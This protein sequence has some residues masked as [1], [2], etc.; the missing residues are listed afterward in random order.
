MDY[1][2]G[3]LIADHRVQ[4][5]FAAMECEPGCAV[6]LADAERSAEA[7]AA[8]C[9]GLPHTVLH[10]IEK[11]LKSDLNVRWVWPLCELYREFFSRRYA[12]SQTYK[13]GVRVFQFKF[14]ANSIAEA[15]RRLLEEYSRMGRTLTLREK[16]RIE[17]QVEWYY[18]HAISDEH[19][20]IRS[21]LK[22]NRNRVRKGV[23]EAQ[24][25]LD[26]CDA[27]YDLW[28]CPGCAA[29]GRKKRRVRPMGPN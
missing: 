16:K 20:A 2:V 12:A 22:D 25:L 5:F 23:R 26:R 1:L 24:A 14:E 11:F 21:I 15:R 29:V 13:A 19:D 9:T 10:R 7:L 4:S 18:R 6:V 17:K 8:F 3:R 27:P 28:S